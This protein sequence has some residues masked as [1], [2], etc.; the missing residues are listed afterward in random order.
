MVNEIVV[1]KRYRVDLNTISTMKRIDMKDD[2]EKYSDNGIILINSVNNTWEDGVWEFKTN[3]GEEDHWLFQKR[4]LL[5]LRE[6][7]FLEIFKED[8]YG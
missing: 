6:E 7:A 3:D 4:H 1:G 5:P 8:I 2:I